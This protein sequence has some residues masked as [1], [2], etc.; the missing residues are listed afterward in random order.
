MHIDQTHKP[1]IWITASAVCAAL[2]LYVPYALRT[3]APGGGTVIG[4]IFGSLAL[5]L[6]IFAALL[7]VRKRF[8]IWRIGRAQIWMR[9]HLWLGILTL[10]MVLF[11]AAFHA[12]GLL[13]NILMWLTWIVVGSG[14]I[15]AWL[16]HTIPMK[17]FREVPF[18]TIYDQIGSIEQQLVGEAD[19]LAVQVKERLAPG[20][21][22]GA[23][24]VL[25]L[26][27]IPELKDEL[28]S[29]ESFYA[30]EVRPYLSGVPEGSK[31]RRS[32][33]SA[34]RFKIYSGLLPESAS[35]PLRALEEIC[36]EKRQLDQQVNMHRLLH[37]WLWCHLPLSG[38]LLLLACVH[39]LGALRY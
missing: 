37:G 39:A 1:W 24:V 33:Y 16:Q 36:E 5:A 34:G 38:V 8:P 32:D 31:M 15:G 27:T 13:S 30:H 6:M 20:P 3:A 35:E 12:R 25:T 26:L 14:V 4:L 17:M 23:T 19:H 21:G 7:S 28:A 22:A 10:P 11:H 18:E 29:F 9:A 2:L